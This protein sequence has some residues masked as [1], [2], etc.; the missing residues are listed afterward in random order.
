[1]ETVVHVHPPA[2]FFIIYI[3]SAFSVWINKAISFEQVLEQNV[4]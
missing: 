2:F 3:Y 1:M 4:A